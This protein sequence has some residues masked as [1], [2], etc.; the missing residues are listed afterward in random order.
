MEEQE[1]FKY[2]NKEIN[3]MHIDENDEINASI[4]RQEKGEESKE[5]LDA[6]SPQ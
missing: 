3:Y 2:F 4:Q 1:E 5:D 6:D